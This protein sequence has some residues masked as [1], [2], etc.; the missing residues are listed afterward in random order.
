MMRP[1][2]TVTTVTNSYQDDPHKRRLFEHKPPPPIIC[3]VMPDR[4]LLHQV[5]HPPEVQLFNRQ[6]HLGV[7]ALNR[8]LKPIMIKST[9]QNAVVV[10]YVG[11]ASSECRYI[12]GFDGA[13]ELFN[14][15]TCFFLV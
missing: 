9:S 7:D 11:P 14:V 12:R 8:Y 15:C 3:L 2:H 1:K 10:Q 5:V 13:S 6:V 4:L